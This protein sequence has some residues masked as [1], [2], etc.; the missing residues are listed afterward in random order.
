MPFEVGQ[1]TRDDGVERAEDCHGGGGPGCG[2]QRSEGGADDDLQH[3]AGVDE[4]IAELVAEFDCAF[5]IDSAFVDSFVRGRA[6]GEGGVGVD[7]VREEGSGRDDT[8]QGL[9]FEE[10]GGATGRVCV[11]GGG[12]GRG[13]MGV[14][15]LGVVG[16]WCG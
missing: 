13:E 12:V 3:V 6:G 8:G 5:F 4:V 16:C 9:E 1:R 7:W 2:A 15:G 10:V 14:G 11:G